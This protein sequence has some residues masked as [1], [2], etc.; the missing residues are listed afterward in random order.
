MADE[1]F[2]VIIDVECAEGD[3]YRYKLHEEQGIYYII[4]Y[5]RLAGERKFRRFKKAEWIQIPS[6]IVDDISK[7]S[8]LVAFRRNEV[9]RP[10]LADKPERNHVFIH[11]PGHA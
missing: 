6:S 10:K 2:A 4:P 11:D 5:V 9:T 3:E 1:Q 8:R 7:N